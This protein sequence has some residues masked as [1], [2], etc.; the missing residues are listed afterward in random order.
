MDRRSEM[1][2]AVCP[3]M[4]FFISG[5]NAGKAAK[6]VR[7][8]TRVKE[9]KAERLKAMKDGTVQKSAR[10]KKG[11][12]RQKMGSGKQ[13]GVIFL[14]LFLVAGIAVLA[15]LDFY[16]KY[17]DGMLYAER[18]N[19]MRE[20]TGQLFNGLEDVVESQW[21]VAE[22]Q[23]NY[24]MEYRPATVD[25]L[26]S[27][28]NRQA[29]LNAFADSQMEMMAVDDTG[30]YYT[31]NGIQGT[32]DGMDYL[33]EEPERISYVYNT[34]TTGQ[35]EMVFLLKL[36]IP[37]PVRV[38]DKTAEVIYYGISRNMTELK[39]Y[40]NCD[41]YDGNN[42]VYVLDIN[43][44]KLF[45]DTENTI[46]QGW[47]LYTVLGKMEY[48]HES[49]FENAREELVKKGVAYSNAILG[50]EEY[51]YSLYQMKN[52]QWIFLFLVPSDCVAT[53]TVK[54]I[55][56]TVRMILIF[57]LILIVICVL[58][59]YIILQIK[60]KQALEAERRNAVLLEEANWALDAKNIALSHA[61]EEARAATRWA[62]SA[63]KE[64]ETA[65][66]AKS[67]FLS[68]MSHD[69]RTPMNA[70]VG[71]SN[72]MEHEGNVSE[73][74][75][76]YIQKIKFSSRHLLSLI[77]DI[78]DM[79]KIE[80]SEIELNMDRVSLAE[81]IGQVDSIIRSQ[82]NEHAQSFTIRVHDI[83][84]EYIIG[85]STRLRQIFLN[86]LSN[87]VKYTQSGGEIVFDITELADE[88]PESA[89]YRFSV[90]DNG[91]GMTQEFLQRIF[92]PFTRAENSVV[93]KVQ[94]TGLG[95]AITKNIVTLMNGTIEVQ[96]EVGKGSRFDVTLT[97]RID[98]EASYDI[99]AKHI[100]LIS[101]DET[102]AR[103]IQAPLGQTQLH[104]TVV[105][106]EEEARKALE[107]ETAE[108][109]LL[110]GHLCDQSLSG[111]VRTMRALAAGAM[112]IFCVDYAQ[113]DQ[114]QE[115]LR[116]AG[117]DGL[118]P[119]PFFLSN[120][121]IAIGRVRSNAAPEMEGLSVLSGMRFLCAEDNSLNAEILEAIL[122]MYGAS[123]TIYPDGA[124][125]V[126]A[127]E[128]VQPGQYDAILMDIQMP[129]MNGYEATRAIRAGKN[130]LGKTIVIIAMTANAFSDDVQNSLLAGM[131]AHISK[132]ID[133]ALLEK[134]V[135]G[136]LPRI[137]RR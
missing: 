124:E 111:T 34:L 82:T 55:D 8:E 117:V 107:K 12:V 115:T 51:Y 96:S 59:I 48:L 75:H 57:A 137:R 78:L 47:N 54:M 101:E 13:I 70:I 61:V 118:I 7:Y 27:L 67:E 77:N 5:R 56:M 53:N 60:Q 132:P 2:D 23:K 4:A 18:L 130:P 72:L 91:C 16:G 131:D 1:K 24:L 30:R 90:M 86:L 42:S 99:G 11:N 109:I 112:M 135:R 79:S 105:S 88:E 26:V 68:N 28:M 71:I 76:G 58:L 46:L 98:P 95:M 80:S 87:S 120:L 31:Q 10:R 32:L 125:I 17:I 66:H 73:R 134:T 65:N 63:M 128:T 89:T 110:A 74:M 20:V 116:Q 41:A 44:A 97:F 3:H 45:S 33:L 94:G 129:H 113:K 22:T 14:S 119:R 9:Q 85:D 133:V 123:C 21:A 122:E 114:V 43:G 127:F 35:S 81:Q 64:A 19:Q 40:F 126:R 93:N 103:N 121:E 83:V 69:I 50:G 25:A 36:E 37:V 29:R 15:F 100:L 49:S 92:E 108:V 6:K 102:L 104:L 84:H 52:A 38:G 136:M 106:T 62:E 39:P